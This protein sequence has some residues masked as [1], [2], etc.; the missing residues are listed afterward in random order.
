MKIKINKLKT[1]LKNMGVK[2]TKKQL[3]TAILEELKQKDSLNTVFKM[4]LETLIFPEQQKVISRDPNNKG[5]GLF[6]KKNYLCNLFIFTTKN[7]KF[8]LLFL[9][10]NDIIK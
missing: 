4:T 10:N 7:T 6:H 9:L 1:R 8:F 3:T 5:T 2:L